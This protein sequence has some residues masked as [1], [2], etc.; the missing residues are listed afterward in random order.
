MSRRG[1]SNR[2]E[3]SPAKKRRGCFGLFLDLALWLILLGLVGAVAVIVVGY[4][5]LSTQL[6]DALAQVSSFESAVGG[7]PRFYDRKGRLLFELPTVEK[8]R[9]LPYTDIP[10][11]VKLATVAVEDDTFW[12]NYGIDPAAI[13]AALYY[14]VQQEEGER[15]VGASTITQQLVR[16]IAFSYSERVGTSYERKIREIL[17][18]LVITQRKSKEDILTLYLNE[19]YYGNLAYGIEAAAQT[20]FGKP[21]ADLD[22]AE[23]AFLAAIPQSPSQWNPYTNYDGVKQRQEFIIDLMMED[24]QILPLDALVAKDSPLGLQPLLP[25]TADPE[26]IQIAPHF[27]LYVLEQIEEQ[28]GR[29]ALVSGGWQVVTTLDLDI[30]KLAESAARERVA[31]WGP[32]HDMTNAAVV[33]MQPQTGELLAMVGSLDYFNEAIDGQIN[34][35]LAPRQP[36]S[37]FKPITFAAAMQKGWS[38][39]DVIWDVPIKLEVGYDDTMVP[40]NYDGRYHGPLLLRDALANSYNIPPLQLARDV[41][42]PHIVTTARRLG[43][44]TLDEVVGH[45]GLS[46]TLGSGE[47]PLLQMTQA[48]ATFANGGERQQLKSILNMTDFQGEL[49]YSGNQNDLRANKVLDPAIAYII[50]DILDDDRARVPAM[51]R[52]S[53]LELAFPAAAKTGTTDDFRDNLTIGYTPNVVV[54]VWMGNTDSQPMRNTSGL[55]GAS[56]LWAA[57][58]RG[59]MSSNEMLSSIAVDGEL[60]VEFERPGNVIDQTLCLP[61]GAGGATCNVSR[62][63]PVIANASVHGVGRL[64]YVPDVTTAPGSWSLQVLPLPGSAAQKVNLA[65]LE[66]GTTPPRPRYCVVNQTVPGSFTRLFLPPPTFYPDEVRAR[67]WAERAGYGGRVA[68]PIACPLEVIRAAKA[69]PP[70]AVPAVN[71]PEPGDQ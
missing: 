49:V 43:I 16:H 35:T 69:P 13:G 52:G 1:R 46:L 31:A 3:S 9:A 28:F 12:E 30:Q 64:A 55:T 60:T 22:L 29:D 19:I 10:E 57:I 26:M 63:E 5:Y 48:Y 8:R 40:V 11:S 45:Y 44:S 17:L 59:I 27:V 37:T 70:T 7:T 68:P 2:S 54:G 24:D 58:M 33:V 18:A 32:N 67:V 50:T 56:P 23:A 38:P 71:T 6:D 62:T 14:N 39:A 42:L 47:V 65:P 36:G 21:A 41:G 15:P 66:D 53:A 25:S 61:S 34:M 20:Y 51:G 4:I